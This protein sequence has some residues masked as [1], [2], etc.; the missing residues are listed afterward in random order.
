MVQWIRIHLTKQGMQIQSPIWKDSTCHR[1]TKAHAPQLRRLRAAAT[2][3]CA[4]RACAPREAARTPQQRV[5]LSPPQ[6]KALAQPPRP[7]ATNS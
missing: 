7:S 3:A 6:E 1:A 4:P 5:A 2:D